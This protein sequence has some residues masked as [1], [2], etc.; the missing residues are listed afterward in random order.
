MVLL[1]IGN[2]EK[3]PGPTCKFKSC[4][5]FTETIASCVRHQYYH[6]R[7]S[8]FMFYC[9]SPECIYVSK[10]FNAL[11]Y[12]VSMFHREIKHQNLED[13]EADK[14]LPCTVLGCPQTMDSFWSLVQ[15]ICVH[16]DSGSPSSGVRCP[17]EDCRHPSLFLKSKTLRVH[18][19][20]YHQGWRDEGA[21]PSKRKRVDK[22]STAG[23]SHFT[24]S[25]GCGVNQGGSGEDIRDDVNDEETEDWELLNDD[26]I[27]DKIAKF[28][29]QLYGEFFLPYETIQEICNGI[30]FICGLNN[31]RMK[32]IMRTGLETLGVE[33]LQ[34]NELCYK[35]SSADILFTTHH[36]N[37][38]GPS[39]TSDYLRKEYFKKHYD[40]QAPD[41][42]SLSN[43]MDPDLKIQYVPVTNTLATILKDPVVQKDVDASF[44]K[45]SSNSD[46]VS[47]YTDGSLFKEENHEKKELH[48]FLY[49][50][51]YNPVMNAL[52]SAKDKYKS[53]VMY[54]TLGNLKDENRSKIDSKHLVVMVRE[55]VFKEVGAKKCFKDALKELKSLETVGTTYKDENIK[56][57]VIYM[58]G[59][60][61]GQHT[62]GGFI[63]CFTSIYFCRF[64]DIEKG[65][66]KENPEHTNPP[67]SKEDYENC[68]REAKVTEEPCKGVKGDCVFNDLQNFHAVSHLCPC[69]AHDLFEGVVSRDLSGII[70]SF[71][72]KKWFSYKLLNKR[73]NKFQCQGIDAPNKPANVRYKGKSK[74]KKLG[75]HA[76]QNWALLR[77]LPFI[78]GDKIKDFEDP[79]WKLYLQLKELC[80]Y[81]CGH[82]FLKSDV[83]YIKDVLVPLYFERR[84]EVLDESMYP[85]KPKYHFSFGHYCELM[86]RYGPLIQV[87]TLGFEQKHKLF[88]HVVRL[89]RNF[90][91]V[92]YTCAMRHQLNLAFKATGPLFHEGCIETDAQIFSIDSYQGELKT[93]LSSMS[94]TQGR[95]RSCKSINVDGISYDI[96]SLLLL[97]S[98]G[99]DI[100]C[101]RIKVILSTDNEVQ[102][103]LNC[104]TATFNN[105][106]GTYEIPEDALGELKSIPARGLKYAQ[107]QPLYDFK[108]KLSFNVKGKVI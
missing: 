84:S 97:K 73:I 44:L 29:L 82:T 90:I 62:I 75:G 86:L 19:S 102:F 55:S 77:L 100:D 76:V 6:S 10:S 72:K 3:N 88:K 24:E 105:T 56:V 51:S 58:L 54:F 53:L 27:V 104:I 95:C 4:G 66:F 107:P 69:I 57:K 45:C 39:F 1:F 12:H 94:I 63:E 71:V 89:S 21:P 26:L 41:E 101:G 18:L 31:L 50:D 59:D 61:L 13:P 96:G 38:P 79:A 33:Q 5:F 83:P 8:N 14:K 9:P 52:G 87:W 42:V 108:G 46:E 47:D 103:V 43:H 2:I 7:S 92:E 78:I 17:V 11:N 93:F 60:N 98:N 68:V 34:A 85:L 106:V 35:V 67:R 25:F 28:Y 49:I 16:L 23:D 65:V 64:C 30:S 37:A 99:R 22:S 36:K 48:L 70:R 15:H 91:N 80:E 20:Q 74:Y 32:K 40:F 81:F